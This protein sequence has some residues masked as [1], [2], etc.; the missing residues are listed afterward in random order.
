[1]ELHKIQFNGG[2]AIIANVSVKNLYMWKRLF[3]IL[4]CVIVKLKNI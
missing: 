3:G 4:V 2:K 1:M